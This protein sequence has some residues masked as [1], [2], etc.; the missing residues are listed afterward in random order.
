MLIPVSYL[1]LFVFVVFVCL[2]VF[3]FVCFFLFL[4]FEWITN[5]FSEHST[6]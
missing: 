2:F 4:F 6:S 3:F 5:C 1:M